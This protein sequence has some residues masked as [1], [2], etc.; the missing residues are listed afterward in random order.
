[1]V[2]LTVL[3]CVCGGERGEKLEARDRVQ[4]KKLPLIFFFFDFDIK[5]FL[6]QLAR[7]YFFLCYVCVC[8]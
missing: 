3:V 8:V 5:T 1:M 2:W 6:P 4:R 7:H